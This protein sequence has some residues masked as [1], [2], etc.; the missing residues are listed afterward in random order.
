MINATLRCTLYLASVVAFFW[1][2]AIPIVFGVPALGG[3]IKP[4]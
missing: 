2:I 1:Y 4:Y 3:L